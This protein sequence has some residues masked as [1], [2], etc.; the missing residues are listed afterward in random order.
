MDWLSSQAA[1][2]WLSTQEATEMVDEFLRN[3][4][5]PSP[6]ALGQANALQAL[7]LAEPLP[8]TV[9]L[10]PYPQPLPA[11]ASPYDLLPA[12]YT[13]PSTDA[14]TA[15]TSAGPTPQ[16]PLAM[17]LLTQPL[18][19]DFPGDVAPFPVA[20]READN[21]QAHP[22]A[23]Y[24]LPRAGQPA[25]AAVPAAISGSDSRLR[26]S[27]VEYRRHRK[28]QKDRSQ[29]RIRAVKRAERENVV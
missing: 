13:P 12:V 25:M 20:F 1:T 17:A 3:L 6:S 19:A 5:P 15:S 2:D 9:G 21:L 22:L 27:K 7:T 28:E 16:Q 14:T 4:P 26:L 8:T 11:V 18:P 29:R 10:P 24:L 23:P